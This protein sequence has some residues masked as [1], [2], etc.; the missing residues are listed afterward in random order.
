MP[1]AFWDAAQ[2]PGPFDEIDPPAPEEPSEPE[3][4]DLEEDWDDGVGDEPP[5]VDDAA[6]AE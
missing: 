1:K 2:I 5:E 4:E 3:D 6:D